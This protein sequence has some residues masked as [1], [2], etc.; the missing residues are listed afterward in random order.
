M[1]STSVRGNNVL[2]RKLDWDAPHDQD[3]LPDGLKLGKGGATSQMITSGLSQ[4]R[5]RCTCIGRTR[6]DID[7]LVNKKQGVN[8]THVDAIDQGSRTPIF[9]SFHLI[10]E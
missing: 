9:C 3:G 5:F 2:E 10:V 1:T 6:I 4:A 7:M 8:K